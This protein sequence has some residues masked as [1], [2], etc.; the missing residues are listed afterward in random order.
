MTLALALGRTVRELQAE[1]TA[2]EFAEWMAYHSISPIGDERADLRAGIVASAVVNSRGG[3]SR[4]LDFMPIV[5]GR[6]VRRQTPKQMLALLGVHARAH[7]E[8]R[9]K[10]NK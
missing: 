3:R 2:E 9:S 7:N 6:A 4:P 5:R 1:L 8:H 10:G